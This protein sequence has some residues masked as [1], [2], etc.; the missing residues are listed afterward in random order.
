MAELPKDDFGKLGLFVLISTHGGVLMGNLITP[1]PK[2]IVLSL[3]FLALN[4]PDN[5]LLLLL[6]S[7]I[8]LNN[9]KGGF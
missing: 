1:F 3:C 5:I 7:V 8:T 6:V 2:F 4:K 9:Q